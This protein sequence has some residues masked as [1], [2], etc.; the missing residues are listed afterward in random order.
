MLP[1][2]SIQVPGESSSPSSLV[3]KLP[4]STECGGVPAPWIHSE[5]PLR[6]P[7]L[8]SPSPL[9]EVLV[10]TSANDAALNLR[11]HPPTRLPAPLADARRSP[12]PPTPTELGRA[13]GQAAAGGRHPR[14]GPGCG[15]TSWPKQT[16][17]GSIP[18]ARPA[19]LRLALRL[20]SQAA[21]QR[22]R[23]CL[24]A[25]TRDPQASDSKSPA[26]RANV[27][28]A[29]GIRV[30]AGVRRSGSRSSGRHPSRR[31]H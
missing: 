30:A 9:V 28:V 12:P 20:G 29:A 10:V 4:M 2:G 25:G 6:T 1:A 13:A 22:P 11:P 21:V 14:P 18:R 31:G 27:R 8:A 16:R 23:P 3:L 5:R 15:V 7:P 24:L 26:S 17:T 19:G